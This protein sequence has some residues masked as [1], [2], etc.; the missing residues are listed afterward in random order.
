VTATNAAICA[1]LEWVPRIYRAF[2]FDIIC[3]CFPG[4]AR[5]K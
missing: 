5:A 2:V 3:G 4:D 1:V